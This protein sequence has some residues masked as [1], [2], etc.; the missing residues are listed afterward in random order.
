MSKNKIK[1]FEKWD[2][3]I[4]SILFL[5]ENGT[6]SLKN[7]NNN[8]EWFTMTGIMFYKEHGYKS[9]K[10]LNDLKGKYWKNGCFK[11]KKVVLHSR[12][13]RKKEGS[14]NPKMIDIESFKE[15]LIQIISD[16]E[17]LVFSSSI[18]KKFLKTNYLYPYPVYSYCLT[19]IIER[20]V[21]FLRD[22]RIKGALVLE[23]RGKREDTELYAKI[24]LLLD[25]GTKFVKGPYS[26]IVEVYF[27]NKRTKDNLDAYPL[28]EVAD[29][30]GYEIF[31]F[32]SKN[33]KSKLYTL[34]SFKFYNYPRIKGYGLKIFK[35]K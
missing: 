34:I 25:E 1:K 29:I 21:C 31:K 7:I 24:K 12:D 3:N 14:F 13:I 17:F 11:D 19:F 26:E 27:N 32:V 6:P 2:K 23:S 33:I 4:D 35:E 5:D 20:Y 15:N 8:N 28:L 30:I 18:N 10:E 9:N 16:S 22:N